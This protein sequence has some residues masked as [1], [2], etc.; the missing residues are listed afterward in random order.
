MHS[1]MT[2]DEIFSLI[3]MSTY[4]STLYSGTTR[5]FKHGKHQKAPDQKK[6]KKKNKEGLT[7][8]QDDDVKWD[9]YV[10]ILKI[11]RYIQF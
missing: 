9:H 10:P 11:F 6:K 7:F 3:W 5:I 4:C 1:C 8:G 2:K